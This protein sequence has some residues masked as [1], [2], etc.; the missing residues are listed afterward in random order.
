MPG[1]QPQ[2]EIRMVG[3]PTSIM[4]LVVAM[5]PGHVDSEGCSD[6]WLGLVHCRWQ[7]RHPD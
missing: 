5:P 3:S 7:R 1:R 6:A 2:M 4:A